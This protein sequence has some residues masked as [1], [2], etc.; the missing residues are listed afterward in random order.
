MRVRHHGVSTN[1]SVVY[2]RCGF[3]AASGVGA[4]L[5][6]CAVVASQPQS[7]G[8][9]PAPSAATP[10]TS[11]SPSNTQI[12]VTGT[13][14]TIQS[15]IDR[16]TYRIGRDLQ[17]ATGSIADVLRNIPSVD[18]DLQGNVTLRGQ[19]NVTILVDGKPTSLFRGAGG[20][21]TLQQLPAS[22]YERVEVMT[23]PSAAFSA[24]GTG[25]IINLITRSS[26]RAGL[27]G[28]LRGYWGTS[29]RRG[30][31]GSMSD[32]VGKLTLTGSG[33]F[34]RDP[35]FSTD[36]VHFQQLDP[37]GSILLDSREVTTGVGNLHLWNA[38]FSAD[39][40][41]DEK[42]R[43]STEFH[44]TSFDY[45]SNMNSNLV[46]TDAAGSISR[47]FDRSGKLLM[48]RSDSEGSVSYR[49]DFAEGHNL[50][51]SL[52][53]EKTIE[54][55][56]SMFEDESSLPPAPVVFDNVT[57]RNNLRRTEFKV[58]YT[59]PLAKN[60]ELQL[61]HDLE[62]DDD[63]FDD[64]G[65]FG[66]D[67]ETAAIPQPAFTEFFR[68]NR[69]IGAAYV[70]LQHPIGKVIVELGLRSEADHL[71]LDSAASGFVDHRDALHLF[72]S[73]HT[74]YDLNAH[75][76]LRVS[77]STRITRPEGN[78]LDP[79]RRFIDPFHFEAGNPALKPEFTQSF[80]LGLEH[81]VGSTLHSV[82]FYYR[83]NDRGVTDLSTDL[84]G[85]ALLTTRENLVG[86]SN[87]GVELVANGKVTKTLTY[88][89]NANVYRYSIDASNLGFGRRSAWIESGKLGLDWE[90]SKK[91][92][93]QANASLTGKTLVPQGEI[94]PML[95]VNLG[96][97]HRLSDR[98]WGFLTAQDALRTYQ[99]HGIVRTPTLIQQTHDSSRTRAAF[100]GVTYSL[101]KV[102][103]DP[104]FDY[105]G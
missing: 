1:F 33:S 42:S 31:S 39:Y 57:S 103:R 22:Q 47:L 89:L 38:R 45:S 85:G 7:T 9:T 59:R 3:R 46:G 97:R 68:F 51:A 92:L 29:G 86:S 74:E 104:S 8:E 41:L 15:S 58:D 67:A 63:S 48:N 81:S 61:G 77:F 76:R 6:T 49:H 52:T 10:P 24:E 19:P 56:G 21:L 102:S 26:K 23:N 98:L 28:S 2:G 71:R 43:L 32:K 94:D 34:R 4:L 96:F 99:Q 65:G 69:T 78:E 54:H 18:V 17:G 70:T 37:A 64:R 82:T 75:D 93:A 60:G 79:F 30:V 14:P 83:H 87:A 50:V 80:E 88:R 73:V 44:H 84:G 12:T 5:W 11:A 66:P 25:G 35:Q 72:P 91:D 95:L 105:N 13:R 27:T 36:I 16:K 40:D 90:P 20:G 53:R 62:I 100:L 55:N 101:G